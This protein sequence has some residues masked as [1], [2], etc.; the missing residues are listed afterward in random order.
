MKLHGITLTKGT[1]GR[2]GWRSTWET[3]RWYS[4]GGHTFEKRKRHGSWN[5]TKD[6]AYVGSFATL[7]HACHHIARTQAERPVANHHRGRHE[8]SEHYGDD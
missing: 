2:T 6:G 5:V 3:R 7:D 1:N 4:D 8:N